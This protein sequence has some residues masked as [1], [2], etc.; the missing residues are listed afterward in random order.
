MAH[1]SPLSLRL[2][3]LGCYPFQDCDPFII[4]EC[5]NIYFIGNQPEYATRLV[6]G[7]QGQQVRV[8]VLP[9]FAA[10]GILA[11]VDLSTLE[12][13]SIQLDTDF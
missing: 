1:P 6:E 12:C 3:L 11:L 4:D 2:F 10:T 5:P 8:V 9:S 7:K 13:H